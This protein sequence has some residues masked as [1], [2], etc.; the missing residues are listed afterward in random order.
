MFSK[1]ISY[2]ETKQV[3]WQQHCVHWDVVVRLPLSPGVLPSARPR[4]S[5]RP[6]PRSKL[7]QDRFPVSSQPFLTHA[8]SVSG[9]YSYD[10]LS[11]SPYSNFIAQE[12][13]FCWGWVSGRIITGDIKLSH[14]TPDSL[15]SPLCR[16]NVTVG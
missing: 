6:L 10:H 4:A 1:H 3:K 8:L 15:P 2:R 7:E 13:L 12:C 9:S 16:G 14:N 5:Q 11:I